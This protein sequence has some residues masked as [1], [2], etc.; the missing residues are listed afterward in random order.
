[1]DFHY[2]YP[3][4]ASPS[5]LWDVVSD[6]LTVSTCIPG[7][8]DVV[9]ADDGTYTGV[10]NVRVG[11]VSLGLNGRITVDALDADARKISLSGEAAD[12]RVPGNVR[13]RI[14]MTVED[15]G[16]NS[17]ELVVDSEAQI[18]GKL[19]EFGQGLIKRKADGMMKDFG[20]NVTKRVQQS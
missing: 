20:E 1:M 18:M 12:K 6:V 5:T 4:N 8:G 3:V 11:P 7:A 17:S 16:A 19:G 14:H 10:V 2:R 13:V 15:K 9:K